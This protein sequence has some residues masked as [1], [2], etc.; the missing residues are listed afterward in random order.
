MMIGSTNRNRRRRHSGFLSHIAFRQSISVS[1]VV[2]HLHCPALIPRLVP[3][4]RQSELGLKIMFRSVSTGP[5]PRPR[6]KQMGS[7]PI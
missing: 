3:I 4:P 7:M 5:R 6:M 2:A 1:G